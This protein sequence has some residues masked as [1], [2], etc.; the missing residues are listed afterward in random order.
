MKSIGESVKAS[1]TKSV[2]LAAVQLSASVY[3]AER[4]ILI[5]SDDA[6]TGSI[7]VGFDNT[8]TSLTGI[9]LKN[10]NDA[11]FLPLDNPATQIYLI[12]S[13]AAQKVR[14]IVI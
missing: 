4:G 1:F 9:T 10:A 5:Q 13:L 7:Y 2:G 12:A 6:N 14:C 8:V 3:S 11:I